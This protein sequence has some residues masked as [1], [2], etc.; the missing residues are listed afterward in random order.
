MVGVSQLWLPILVSSLAV[1][2]IS[3]IIWMV[4]PHHKADIKVLPDEKMFAERITP[5]NIPPGTYMWPNCGSGEG[6]SSPEFKS[7]MESGP[8]GSLNVIGKK[9]SFA[10]NLVAVFSVYVVVGVFV[11][12]ITSQ[13]RGAGAAFGEVFQV[14]GA[15]AMLGYGMGGLP[16][17]IFFSKP[18]RFVM[19]EF[20]DSVVYA[21]ATAATFAWLW[22]SVI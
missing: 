11:A 16:G 14:A 20:L 15:T 10:F 4:L 1:F 12:Y 17:A 9:P 21:L 22:P 13:S 3:S 7:R 8:W 19:T 2:F 5:L 6:P 18:C